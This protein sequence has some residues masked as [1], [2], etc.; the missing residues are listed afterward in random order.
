MLT[1][2]GFLEKERGK[3]NEDLDQEK[4]KPMLTGS[5][6]I[7]PKQSAP[8]ASHPPAADKKRLPCAGAE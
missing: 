2:N 4:P 8:M 5:D 6:G 1:A 7:E 3:E